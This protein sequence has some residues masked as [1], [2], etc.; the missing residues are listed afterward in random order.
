MKTKWR[1]SEAEKPGA[2]LKMSQAISQTLDL[3]KIL[4]MSCEMTT[5][6]LKADRCSIAL[7]SAKNTF[8]I[9][10]SYRRKPS[11]PS[12]DGMRF[13]LNNY[14]HIGQALLKGKTVHIPEHKRGSLSVKEKAIFKRLN[15]KSF[16]GVPILVG[17]K[18]I[19]AVVPSRIEQHFAF[20]A[21]DL[22]LCKA[23]ANHVGIA[24]TNTNLIKSLREKH[25]QLNA[26]Q[27]ETRLANERLRYLMF[28]TSAVIYASEASGDYGAT[29]ITDNVRRMTGYTP[30]QF[31]HNSRFWIDHIHPED[32]RRILTGL[33]N[34]F[35]KDYHSYDYRFRCKNGKYIW[36]RDEMKL[37]R[38]AKGQPLEIIGFWTDITEHRKAEQVLGESEERYR[39]L[40]EDSPISLW[41][42]DFS[43]V[44]KYI[45]GLKSLG[46]R[47]FRKYFEKHPE[48]I[49]KGAA[50]VRVVDVNI[51]TLKLYK[52]KS[53]D[54]LKRNLS[55][56]F[57]EESYPVCKE[58]LIAIAEGRTTFESD[59][60]N[61]TLKGELIHI[62]LRWSVAP[63]HEKALS[64]VLV[65]VINITERKLAEEQLSRLTN[66]VIQAREEER[67]TLAVKLHDL[68][69][70]D[71]GAAQFNLK[72][73]RRALP[74]GSNQI[75]TNLEESVQLLQTSVEDLRNLTS[76]LR[77][78]I[79]DDFG[80][81][82][83]LRWYVES[84]NRRTGLKIVLKARKL[85]CRL[86]SEL[87]TA[88][89]RMVQEGLA[90]I[91]KHSRAKAGTV[92][93][94]QEG[95]SLCIKI[96]DDGIGLNHKSSSFMEGY[97]LFSLRETAKLLKGKLEISSKAGKGTKLS[98]TIPVTAD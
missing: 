39:R 14:P 97:G 37:V 46:V 25:K 17:R 20:S 3:E 69:A 67:K 9:I 71:L 88:I 23:I 21:S 49:A 13:D 74:K 26:S 18:T 63:G 91:S 35:E 24:I 45:D 31:I 75:R 66:K 98:I 22:G 57:T 62:N 78:P 93:L 8:E 83:A 44:K 61:Q 86:S 19:G 41:D 36:A 47:D 65:S 5:R 81:A 70:Q 50:L 60:I 28:S 58:E 11:Y 59:A 48:E 32:V 12:I 56:V 34:I 38:D 76:D 73:I 16:L 51:A 52:A 94:G 27:E 2:V 29:F 82:S 96:Q 10:E 33:P 84:F 89:Y 87:E 72:L 1:N 30:Q 6:I 90:N 92:A 68:V 40:F 43:H 64:K 80:L 15:I 4:A 42:E 54:E 79:L 85:T 53:K 7:A 95:S 77:P 55:L